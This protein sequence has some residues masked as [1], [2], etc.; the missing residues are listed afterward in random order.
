[1]ALRA[2][3]VFST[4][5]ASKMPDANLDVIAEYGVK[6]FLAVPL[7]GAD[8]AVLGM[9]GVL[10]RLDGTGISPED[11]RRARALSNQV[12][13]VLGVAHNLHSSELHRR[14]AE[15][16]MELAHE[17]DGVLRLPDFARRFVRR[18]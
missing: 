12:A 13:V 17:I 14:R 2:K 4:D 8:G 1:K 7:L 18:A 11:I 15:A 6:Q 10:D 16:M 5:D 3:E 9:F